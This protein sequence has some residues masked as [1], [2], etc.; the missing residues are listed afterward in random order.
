MN[1][2]QQ[3]P[4]ALET[5]LQQDSDL[6]FVE[7]Y[8][9]ALLSDEPGRRMRMSVLAAK[10]NCELSRLSHLVGRLQKRGL[11]EREAD[12]DNGRYTLA[13]LT[14]AGFDYL[15]AAAPGHVA[16]VRDLFVDALTPTELNTLRKIALKVVANVEE[17]R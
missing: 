14:D 8:V 3:L 17:Q 15:A 7:Y 6:S 11:V 12:P 4:A 13:V 16:R 9:L 2:M 5:R 1:L 10:V